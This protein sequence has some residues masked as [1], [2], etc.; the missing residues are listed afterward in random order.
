VRG[1]DLGVDEGEV[2]ADV[3]AYDRVM[4]EEV[5]E[6]PEDVV[7]RRGLTHL[8]VGQTRERGDD[9]GNGP[10]RIDQ[11]MEEGDWTPLTHP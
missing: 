6:F 5:G 4:G 3:V 9:L 7:D 10:S 8:S 2:E 1:V 11:A